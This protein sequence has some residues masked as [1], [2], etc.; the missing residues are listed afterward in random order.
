MTFIRR[1]I[2]RLAEE[3]IW[4]RQALES[5][6]SSYSSVDKT[7]ATWDLYGR[8]E[9]SMAGPDV[10][11][12]IR[13][14]TSSQSGQSLALFDV[15]VLGRAPSKGEPDLVQKVADAVKESLREITAGELPPSSGIGDDYPSDDSDPQASKVNAAYLMPHQDGYTESLAQKLE[16]L[17]NRFEELLQK[18]EGG[19]THE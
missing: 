3:H 7:D 8:F 13:P 15:T 19:H 9:E 4:V 10:H 14:D 11:I 6:S 1:V 16:G 12:A 18:Y 2:D 5:L 17:L